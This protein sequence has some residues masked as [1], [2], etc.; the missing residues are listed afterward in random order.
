VAGD[1][2]DTEE[3]VS[4][5]FRLVVNLLPEVG[6]I[7]SEPFLVDAMEDGGGEIDN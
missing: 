1:P 5:L 4:F 2:G 7:S 6:M 3:V